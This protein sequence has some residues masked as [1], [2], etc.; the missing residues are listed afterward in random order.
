MERATDSPPSDTHHAAE[1]PDEEV[2]ENMTAAA[3]MSHDRAQRFYSRLRSRIQAYVEKKGTAVEKTA[4]YLLLVPDMFNLLWRLVN[5][6]RVSG[7]NK[8]LLGSGIAYFVFPF[9]VIPEAILGPMGYLDDLVFAAYVLNRMLIDTDVSILRD[10]WAGDGDILDSI[11]KILGA[12]D[13]LVETK[14]AD[15]LKKM[16]K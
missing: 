2:S 16:M 4:D 7:K 8:I 5:D 1:M 11:R 6:S 12:A 14:V 15:K 10:H 3:S 13:T 9:D